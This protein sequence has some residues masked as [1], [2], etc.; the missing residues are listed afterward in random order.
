[1]NT[2]QLKAE[3]G[4]YTRSNNTAVQA[5]FYVKTQLDQYCKTITKVKGEYPTITSV[6]T[7]VL[8]RFRPEWD[9]M[10]ETK[11]VPKI[12]KSKRVKVNFPIV[13]AEILGTWLASAQYDEKGQK[14]VMPISRFIM[15]NELKPKIEEDKAWLSINGQDNANPYGNFQYAFPGIVA[16]I[17]EAK[18]DATNPAYLV[19][20]DA[21][22][23]SNAIEQLEKFEEGIPTKAS[24]VIKDIFVSRKIMRAYKTDV[25]NTYGDN[26]DFTARK[27][28][29]SPLDG[30]N[31]VQLDYLPDDVMF[32]TIPGNMVRLV[33]YFNGPE[34]NDIQVQD[35]TVK[36]F[37]EA[38]MGYNF[39]LN[40]A[41]FVA[42]FT[43]TD[44]GF[45]AAGSGAAAMRE[46]FYVE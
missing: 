31:I 17:N 22:T 8:Q 21:I 24:A 25:R 40:Q 1:M 44:S 15:E 39:A 20:L 9:A 27:Q 43:N 28:A 3:L 38:E 6:T 45:A 41:V 32:A 23:S 34:I 13:P 42:N 16:A 10:G 11:F 35:Y 33:D 4:A 5:M 26:T 7:N 30:Y 2:A 14:T 37:G 46:L 18:A 19:P 36:V 12:L 29:E